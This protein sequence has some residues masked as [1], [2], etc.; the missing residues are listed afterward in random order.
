M[1]SPTSHCH[2]SS[3]SPPTSFVSFGFPLHPS[4]ETIHCIEWPVGW[5]HMALAGISWDLLVRQAMTRWRSA[6][7]IRY[8]GPPTRRYSSAV[9]L[10]R[11]WL[12]CGM[13]GPRRAP[14]ALNALNAISMPAI[15]QS[16]IPCFQPLHGST[17]AL[18]WLGGRSPACLGTGG[19]GSWHAHALRLS[20]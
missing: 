13:F 8:P 20:R 10:Q 3:P 5:S 11:S 2:P 19:L 6:S 18:A 9:P 15:S 14:L 4:H 1:P 12:E 7:A 16:I 17:R